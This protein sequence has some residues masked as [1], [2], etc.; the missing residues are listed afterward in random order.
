MLYDRRC[1]HITIVQI[2]M[3]EINVGKFE[4]EGSSLSLAFTALTKRQLFGLKVTLVYLCF[5]DL[6]TIDNEQLTFACEI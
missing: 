5:I 2:F 1:G 4:C 6:Y 3:F